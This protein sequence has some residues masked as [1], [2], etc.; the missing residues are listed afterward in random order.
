MSR[1]NVNGTLKSL[2]VRLG[3]SAAFFLL[4]GVLGFLLV[5]V[6]GP[7][8]QTGPE[9]VVEAIISGTPLLIALGCAIAALTVSLVH[10]VR[11]TAA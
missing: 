10:R 6:V 8:L 4:L 11:H 1:Y 2:Q 5:K 3:K 7:I 9:L